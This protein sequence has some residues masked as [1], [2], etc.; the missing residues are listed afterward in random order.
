MYRF[1]GA[2]LIAAL[3]LGG[4]STVTGPQAGQ[5]D[6]QIQEPTMKIVPCHGKEPRT[7]RDVD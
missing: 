2:V 4:C 7:C 6:P 1:I 5:N 3:G